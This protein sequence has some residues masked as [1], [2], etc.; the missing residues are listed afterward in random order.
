MMGAGLFSTFSWRQAAAAIVAAMA[1]QVTI[2]HLMG[3]PAICACGHLTLWYGDPAGPESSQQLTDW[4]SWTHLL[5][6]FVFY[7]VLRWAAPGTPFPFRLALAAG[8][9]VGWELLEN[10][11][12][13]MARYRQTALA[14]G[15]FGDSIVN[16]LSDTVMALAGM[17][18]ARRLPVPASIVFAVAVELWLAFAIRDNLTLNIVELA[19][20]SQ[21]LSDWQMHR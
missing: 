3:H 17:V 2:L 4:Y 16:S 10:S 11:P 21:A 20:P 7:A 12:A 8:L 13:L 5:H 9:E 14:R 1:A 15:Y 19:W 18:L 6:G